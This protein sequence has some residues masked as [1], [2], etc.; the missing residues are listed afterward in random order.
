MAESATMSSSSPNQL[1]LGSFIHSVALGQLQYLHNTAICVNSSGKIVAVKQDC[2]RDTAEQTLLPQLGWA[3][4]SVTITTAQ[5]GQFFFPGFIDTHVHAPQ[6]PNVGIF[7]KSTLLDWLNTY[8]F[9]MESSMACLSKARRVYSQCIRKSLS[10]G[11]TT[12]SYFAT[13]HV[14]ATNLLADLCLSMGQR[15]FVGRVCM[16][17][18][19]PDHYLDESPEQSVSRTREVINHI[20]SVDPEYALITPIITPRFAPSCS[21]QTMTA[22][23]ELQKETALPVQTHISEN[24]NEI[25]LVKQQFPGIETYTDVYDQH[26]LL[27]DK[28]I[29]AHAIHLSESEADLISQRQSKVAHC[30]CSNSS[31]TSGEARVRWLL[32]KGISVGLGTDMSGGYSPSILEAA[33]LASLVSNHLAMPGVKWPE[34]ATD[35]ERNKVKLS[36][37]EVLH[38]ATRGGA[39]VVGLQDRIGGFD[40]GKEWDAQLIKLNAVPEAE[41]GVG[42]EYGGNVDVFGWETWEE[43]IAKWLYNGDDRNTSRVWVKGRLVHEK[44]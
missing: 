26:G 41:D 28:T 37:E 39:E 42:S 22:L 20:Q 18:L 40:V 32:E 44:K 13:I 38:L 31:I 19:A 16:D 23:G 12:A 10:H 17:Q 43:R 3:L 5:D 29:L 36:V 33:R 6:Y 11:T 15:A 8:T 27:T 25:N 24:N 30:P 14:P 21:G 2:D 4:D 34:N 9:P 1:F 7:G 35:E